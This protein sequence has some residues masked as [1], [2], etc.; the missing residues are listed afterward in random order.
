MTV[1]V[2]PTPPF[3]FTTVTTLAATTRLQFSPPGKIIV[4]LRPGRPVGFQVPDLSD[5]GQA[6]G[7][8]ICLQIQSCEQY[9]PFRVKGM[10]LQCRRTLMA[11]TSVPLR[12]P[13]GATRLAPGVEGSCSTSVTASR[14]QR[15]C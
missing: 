12:R 2:L 11:F 7:V 10:G 8:L 15:Q 9:N 4:I 3:M 6:R 14:D 1:V 13:Y 5:K